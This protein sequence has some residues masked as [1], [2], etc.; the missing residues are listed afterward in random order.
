[1]SETIL[2]D[3]GKIIDEALGLRSCGIGK[4]PH[5]KH[6]ETCQKL[7]EF[8]PPTF[9]ATALI[10]KIY[11]QVK[12]NWKKGVNCEPSTENW[13][14]ESRMNIDARN[15]DPEIKLE[16]AIVGTQT[17]SHINWANQT[18]TSSGF[19]GPHADKHRNID[20]IHRIADRAYEFIEL[21]VESNTPLY[22]AMEILQYAVLYIFSRENERKMEGGSAKQ[23]LLRE[24]T[25]IHL[26]V[27][28]PCSY[29]EGYRLEWLEENI[30]NGL[31]AFLARRMPKLQMDFRFD[32]FPPWF[33]SDHAKAICKDL[34]KEQADSI[35]MAVD[36]RKS[37]YLA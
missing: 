8:P 9:D 37:V 24:A 31:K 26:R 30:S 22:A 5:Y 1:M 12:A 36:N 21:K 7:S 6:K 17:Q 29:Y 28:A 34:S 18:P 14:F 16:R 19:V 2:K 4:E 10:E 32:A 15:D 20:L 13:R 23:K 3:V 25:V 33:S 35:R 11:A 27:L